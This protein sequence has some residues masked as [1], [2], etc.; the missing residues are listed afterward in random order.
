MQ[1][2]VSSQHQIGPF[3]REVFMAIVNRIFTVL[4]KPAD[5]KDVQVRCKVRL[6]IH[7]LIWHKDKSSPYTDVSRKIVLQSGKAYT[8][9]SKV[10]MVIGGF[11]VD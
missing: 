6:G 8:T 7:D 11:T 5:E 4:G 10:I 9:M 1:S 2:I 3:L